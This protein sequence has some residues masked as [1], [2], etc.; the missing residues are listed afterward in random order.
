MRNPPSPTLITLGRLVRRHRDAASILQTDLAKRLGYLRRVAEQHRDRPAPSPTRTHHRPRTGPRRPAR[1][2]HGGLRPS[3]GREPAGL[4]ARLA[5][6]GAPRV[7]APGIRTDRGTR[8]ASRRLAVQ[9]I[10]SGVRH[11][12]LRRRPTS[13]GPA[14]TLSYGSFKIPPTLSHGGMTRSSRTRP[15]VGLRITARPVPGAGSSHSRPVIAPRSPGDPTARP[16]SHQALA[17]KDRGHRCDLARRTHRGSVP[18]ES[19]EA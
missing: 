7:G 6:R 19:A 13:R 2:A 16:S 5:R 17:R 8:P 11:E 14:T 4:D 12:G 18:A 10:P 1:R 9:I 15:A 3:G